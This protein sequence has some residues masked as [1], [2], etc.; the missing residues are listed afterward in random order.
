[1]NSGPSA[2]ALLMDG[3]TAGELTPELVRHGPQQLS[4]LEVAVVLGADRHERSEDR[5]GFRNGS[6]P[7]LLTTQVGNIDLQIPKLRSGCFLPSILEPHRR[8]DQAL[9]AVVMEAYVTGVSTRKVDAL[10]TALGSQHSRHCLAIRVGRRCKAKNVV[11][12]LEVLTSVYPAP[13]YIRCDNGPEFIAHSLRL[14]SERSQTMTAYIE[15]AQL[16]QK[17][18]AESFNRR[19]RDEFLKTELFATVSEAQGFSDRWRW[20]YNPLRP[21]STLQGRTLL[22][23][24]HPVAA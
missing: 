9:Y 12:V 7:R 23:A 16:W 8:V 18:S 15:Q 1:M 2:L 20:E 4:E 19:V 13:T 10:V 24:A 11:A 17:V 3:S 5:V 14:W 22:E 21:P 6:Q